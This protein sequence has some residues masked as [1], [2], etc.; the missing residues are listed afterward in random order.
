MKNLKPII[1]VILALMLL[2]I[3]VLGAE[4]E[5]GDAD[6]DTIA[7]NDENLLSYSGDLVL[8]ISENTEIVSADGAPFEGEL[9]GHVL[10]AFYKV[11]MTSYPGQTTPHKIIVLPETAVSPAQE[12][13]E[14]WSELSQA[15][16]EAG[17]VVE[18]VSLNAPAAYV[19]SD[20]KI[21][22]PLRAIAEALDY[23]VAWDA[24][25]RSVTLNTFIS[26]SIEKDSY[27]YARMAPISLGAAPELTD[28]ATYVPITFFTEVLR[29]NNAY[30][31]EGQIIIDNE[32]PMD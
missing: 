32:E 26:L 22:L 6:G 1:A 12:T 15:V 3:P 10:A 19:N 4:P 27:I 11:V 29:M 30:F 14:D 8:H 20:G 18:G 31:F 28:N 9:A 7:S 16:S 2:A 23:E 5:T 17:I 24:E 25:S 13:P 21:M